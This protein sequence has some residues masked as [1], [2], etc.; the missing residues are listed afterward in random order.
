MNG[1]TLGILLQQASWR[2]VDEAKTMGE[3]ALPIIEPFSRDQ[4]F[5]KRQIAMASA[6]A[7]GGEGAGP[8]LSAGL[9]DENVNV[10]LEA[11]KALERDPNPAATETVLEVLEN[12]PDEVVREMLALAAGS[13]PGDTTVEVLKKVQEQ[14]LGQISINAQMAL[15]KLGSGTAKQTVVAELSDSLPRTRYDALEKLVYINDP[16][17]ARFAVKLL[18][19]SS[20]AVQIGSVKMP[21][22]RRVCDQAVDTLV[23]LLKLQV[24]FRASISTI[25]PDRDIREVEELVR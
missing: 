12:G 19:D 20:P 25:Y 10:R 16:G 22:Y 4:D 6:G 21:K 2:A 9:K 15:A 8:I 1:N 11:A 23:T 17:L 7:A 18:G 3:S 14:D 13:L 24:S 5:A